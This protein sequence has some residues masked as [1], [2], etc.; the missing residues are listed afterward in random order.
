MAP[1]E[2]R[3]NVATSRDG[4]LKDAKNAATSRCFE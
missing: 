1:E 4:G 3:E 2:E